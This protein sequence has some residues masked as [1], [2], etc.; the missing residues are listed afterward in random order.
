MRDRER[1]EQVADEARARAAA[2][3][4]AWRATRRESVRGYIAFQKAHTARAEAIRD[5]LRL[6]DLQRAR[7]LALE[8]EHGREQD[9]GLS[10]E[11]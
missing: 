7:E 9:R 5:E 1:A 2:A 3:A 8:R 4:K 6:R 11:L 10:H